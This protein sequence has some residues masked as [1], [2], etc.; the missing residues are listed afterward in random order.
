MEAAVDATEIIKIHHLY[1]GLDIVISPRS[2]IIQNS[3]AK[4]QSI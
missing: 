2:R 4:Y 1:T 3:V